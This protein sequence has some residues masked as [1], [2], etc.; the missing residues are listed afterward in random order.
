MLVPA[1]SKAA[2]WFGD[3]PAPIKKVGVIAGVLLVALVALA[4]AFGAI[5]AAIGFLLSPVGLIILAIAAV[6]VGVYLLWTNWD[7]VWNWIKEHP[8]YAAVIA[9]F[10]PIIGAI[11]ATVGAVKYLYENWNTIWNAIQGIAQTVWDA[12]K[13]YVMAG[14]QIVSGVVAFGMAIVQGKWGE[15]WNAVTQVL[16]GVWAFIKLAVSNGVSATADLFASLPGRIA[17]AMSGVAS[18]LWGPFRNGLNEIIRLYNDFKIPGFGVGPFKTPEINTPNVPYLH[19]G[20]IFD[21]KGGEGLAMLKSGEGVFTPDQMGALGAGA[22]GGGTTK[23]TVIVQSG[24]VISEAGFVE[25]VRSGMIKAARTTP[26]TYLP[27]S[28]G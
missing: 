6:A 16:S 9:L 4:P 27:V 23:L 21:A 10:F 20:G 18:A 7:K 13:G 14:M 2:R 8:A 1:L 22:V 5:G 15:A 17:R 11:V 3:L 25:M 12:V 26:G 19:S 24:E 28:T